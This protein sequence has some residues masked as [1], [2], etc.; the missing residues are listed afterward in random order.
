MLAQTANRKPV[1]P[2]PL[3]LDVDYPDRKLNRVSS[4]FRFLWII[5]I[6]IVAGMLTGGR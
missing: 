5:P 1:K 2:F 4:A 6:A 3:R